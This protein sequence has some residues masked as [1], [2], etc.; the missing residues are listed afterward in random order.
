[1]SITVDSTN[2]VAESDETNNYIKKSALPQINVYLDI[3]TD[4]SFLIPPITNYIGQYAN[5]V[6]SGQDVNIYVGRKNSNIP[7]TKQTLSTGQ[8]WQL[9]SNLVS[10]NSK[11]EGLPY[12]GI[13]ARKNN[14][15]YVFGNDVDGDIASLRKL[16]ANQQWYFSKSTPER[17]DYV[18]QEDL[19]G[20]FVFDYL[21]T[22]DNQPKYRLNNANFARV[23]DN[24]LNSNVYNLAIKR[25]LTTNDNTSLRIKHVNAELSP[26]FRNF[27]N[28]GPVVLARGVWSNLFTW[29][30]FGFELAT[31]Q[32]TSKPRDTWLI[33]ITGGP[34]TECPTCPNYNFSTLTDYYWP[35]LIAGVQAYSS[36]NNIT[37]V[38]FSN[39]CR[40]ALRSLEKYQNTGKIN[41]SYYNNGTDW[42]QTNLVANPRVVDTFVAVGCPGIM[43]AGDSAFMHIS[44]DFGNKILQNLNTKNHVTQND[45]GQAIKSQCGNYSRV[46]SFILRDACYTVAGKLSG[47]DS[48]SYNLVKDYNNWINNGNGSQ[49]GTGVTVNNFLS[50]YGTLPPGYNAVG[51]SDGLVSVED[52]INVAGTVNTSNFDIQYYPYSFHFSDK[53][54][55][56]L[57][58]R[59]ETKNRIKNFINR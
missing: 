11:R 21:H 23:V 20:L 36:N 56:S 51:S 38:G 8:T 9:D 2:L 24:V 58:D 3:A 30:K 47:A 14:N 43:Q 41:A 6:S 7:T 25:V 45:T 57:P 53:E 59:L 44:R 33:E 52:T 48:I 16:V 37:Y 28:P 31:G 29:E 19:D 49:V 17:V 10:F 13:V 26:K 22:N 34:N 15:I 50:I 39:G 4:Y 42:I 32:G 12:N 46:F 55:E 1:M 40:T 5:I 35:A 18:A 27:T 54:Q